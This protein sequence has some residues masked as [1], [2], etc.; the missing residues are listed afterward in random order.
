MFLRSH[1]ADDAELNADTQEPAP[2][3]LKA[4]FRAIE[5]DIRSTWA[6]DHYESVIL[7]LSKKYG[8][9]RLLEV[10]GGRDPLLPVHR[11]HELG[12]HYTINDISP[13]ELA[14]APAGYHTACFDIAGDLQ[15]AEAER[16]AYD[17][18]FSRMVFEHVADVRQAWRN[19]NSLLAPGGVSLAFMPTLYALPYVAN[20]M[21]PEAV[22]SKIVEWLYPH[23]TAS[24]DPKFPAHY[25]WCYSIESKMLPMLKD[26]GFSDAEIIP[27][28]GHDYFSKLPVLREADELLTR[29]AIKYDWRVLTS[30][31]Y[32]VVRK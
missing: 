16:G 1:T 17:L 26:A 5:P 25:D 15:A 7:D 31:A 23:R 30:Y 20:L 14:N 4:H 6:W 29:L 21:I 19:V 9:S 8:L 11:V 2:G 22:S 13:G 3:S 18:I 12:L 32:I 27:F 24:E 10:G 28:Y